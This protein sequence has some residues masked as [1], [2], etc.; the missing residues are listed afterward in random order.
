MDGFVRVRIFQCEEIKFEK[1]VA[2]DTEVGAVMVEAC[3]TCTGLDFEGIDVN[4]A[5]SV[6]EENGHLDLR[7]KDPKK[8]VNH[9]AILETLDGLEVDLMSVLGRGT[10]AEV[11]AG[12]KLGVQYAVKVFKDEK[13]FEEELKRVLLLPRSASNVL[14]PLYQGR[15]EKGPFLVFTRMKG[16][17]LSIWLAQQCQNGEVTSELLRKCASD[18]ADGMSSLAGID[19][20]RWIKHGDLKCDNVFADTDYWCKLMVG[21]LG[22]LHD[23][24]ER[25]K[26]GTPEYMAPELGKKEAH[27]SPNL[28]SDIWSYGVILLQLCWARVHSEYKTATQLWQEA[29]WSESDDMARWFFSGKHEGLIGGLDDKKSEIVTVLIG[30]V[31]KCL[32]ANESKRLGTWGQVLKELKSAWKLT[33]SNKKYFVR[34]QKY[35]ERDACLMICTVAKPEWLPIFLLKKDLLP[36]KDC[37]ERL[38]GDWILL[39][40]TG[41]GYLFV[42]VTQREANEA[43]QLLVRD[44]AVAVRNRL[45][46]PILTLHLHEGT[47]KLWHAPKIVGGSGG[48]MLEC[49]KDFWESI[50]SVES[51]T[52]GVRE[53]SDFV[54]RLMSEVR[55]PKAALFFCSK[56]VTNDAAKTFRMVVGRIM[57]N[58]LSYRASVRY[59]KLKDDKAKLSSGSS[60]WDV[61]KLGFDWIRRVVSKSETDSLV[62]ELQGIA[63]TSGCIEIV[64]AVSPAYMALIEMLVMVND[65]PQSFVPPVKFEE[66][67]K[68][69]FSSVARERGMLCWQGG[70]EFEW[71]PAFDVKNVPS[72]PNSGGNNNNA[73]P[74]AVVD[75]WMAETVNMNQLSDHTN[76]MLKGKAMLGDPMEVLRGRVQERLLQ[77]RGAN[78]VWKVRSELEKHYSTFRVDGFGGEWSERSVGL[79]CVDLQA[80]F[81]LDQESDVTLRAATMWMDGHLRQMV[82]SG[83]TPLK[84]MAFEWAEQGL[85][86]DRFDVVVFL[87][88]RQV[89]E[90]KRGALEDLLSCFDLNN[91]A[92]LLLHRWCVRNAGRV[93]WMLDGWNEINIASGTVLDRI[94]ANDESG[95]KCLLAGSGRRDVSLFNTIDRE[96]TVR[97]F[98]DDG[99]KEFIRRFFVELDPMSAILSLVPSSDL[100]D[101]NSMKTGAE[102]SIHPDAE[103]LRRCLQSA[104]WLR[105]A[106]KTPRLLSLVCTIM[107]KLDESLLKT[108]IYRFVVDE[109]LNQYATQEEISKLRSALGLLAWKSFLAKE[110]VV[111]KTEFDEFG[112]GCDLTGLLQKV[113]TLA[114]QVS[115]MW[116]HKTIREYLASEHICSNEFK[117]DMIAELRELMIRENRNLFFGFVCGI[118][119]KKDR[120]F[121]WWSQWYPQEF[122][123]YS[124]DILGDVG[125][126]VW[127]EEGG[128]KLEK[129]LEQLWNPVF[130]HAGGILLRTAAANACENATK[131]L[132][133]L[134]EATPERLEVL[135]G[136]RLWRAACQGGSIFIVKMFAEL[137]EVNDANETGETA[138]MFAAHYGHS[139]I[140]RFLVDEGADVDAVQAEGYSALMFAVESGKHDVIEVLLDADAELDI[141]SHGGQTALMLASRCGDDMIASLLVEFGAAT[142]LEDEYGRTALHLASWLGNYEVVEILVYCEDVNLKAREINGRTALML[143]SKSGYLDIVGLLVDHCEDFDELGLEDDKGRTALMLAAKNGCTDVVDLLLSFGAEMDTEDGFGRT[144]LMLASR[145]GHLE[146]VELLIDAGADL[147]VGDKKDFNA[148]S[149][150]SASGHLRIVNLLFE[151]GADV[152]VN[153]DGESPLVLASVNGHL[154]VVEYLL[155]FDHVIGDEMR[156]VLDRVDIELAIQRAL[157]NEHLEIVKLLSARL[158][159]IVDEI[160]TKITP[161][162]KS[163]ARCS[164]RPSKER[165]KEKWLNS[166]KPEV[167]ERLSWLQGRRQARLKDKREMK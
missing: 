100:N 120:P 78:A 148:I 33:D 101:K 62:E 98:S 158:N 1:L 136:W 79:K 6:M 28:K 49:D 104:S 51:I 30:L 93:L 149:L 80:V 77:L 150:A 56:R 11:F 112:V 57:E 157:H 40:T 107:H 153:S 3:S 67:E 81:P 102:R 135:R 123:D 142:D 159:V 134:S 139:E 25:Q 53:D 55:E 106:C 4:V 152:M 118:E 64:F 65:L 50:R 85:W 9:S 132:L 12:Q 128:T 162:T 76:A 24:R 18:L 146:V 58:T 89:P 34:D 88:L 41:S 13:M 20:E 125:P 147:N 45:K 27:G 156:L 95:V 155:D 23:A 108:D 39:D 74:M 97:G 138:L 124:S 115:F 86:R 31:S 116:L 130:K 119:G 15:H 42:F 127:I 96:L 44:F 52:T 167:T 32:E 69:Y 54:C 60:Y 73:A 2:R 94:R 46:G 35:G 29:G 166:R 117:G 145:K 141:A 113:G 160:N 17:N 109:E 126:V 151:E 66:V 21:D 122:G 47:D 131:F 61:A 133:R 91:D 137:V 5:V 8:D 59:V 7:A 10:T 140:T 114:E 161:S 72:L 143:A 68:E 82:L 92:V 26:V 14:I 99:V 87:D 38:L 110:H 75:D 83:V 154:D 43:L 129:V 144:A 37:E 103:R 63:A 70:E 163:P 165:A 111:S 84:R 105:E 48:K 16:G 121:E 90:A 19:E 71:L 164:V 36:R 22:S